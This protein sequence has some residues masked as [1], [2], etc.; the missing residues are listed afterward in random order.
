MRKLSLS[1]AVLAI[2]IIVMA[3]ATVG[4]TAGA[5]GG[6]TVGAMA[7]PSMSKAPTSNRAAMPL[8]Q[9]T[10]TGAKPTTIRPV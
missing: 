9:P 7:R 5:M 8:N 10:Q 3:G 6:I 4:V 2:A 1:T